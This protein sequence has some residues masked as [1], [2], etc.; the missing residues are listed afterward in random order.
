VFV[1][2]YLFGF[3]HWHLRVSKT[4]TRPDLQLRQLTIP[5]MG[6]PILARSKA[7]PAHGLRMTTLRS[8]SPHTLGGVSAYC[9]Y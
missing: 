5:F 3:T 1:E 9:T 7:A 6:S 4:V 2:E 8:A